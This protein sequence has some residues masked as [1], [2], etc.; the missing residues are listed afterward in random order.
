MIKEGGEPF[1][2]PSQ[3]R[4]ASFL[5]YDASLAQTKKRRTEK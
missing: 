2:V 1:S 5:F 4:F 3:Y